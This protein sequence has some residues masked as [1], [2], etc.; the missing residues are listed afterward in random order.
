MTRKMI[1]RGAQEFFCIPCLADHF[2]LTEAVLRESTDVFVESPFMLVRT[3]NGNICINAGIDGSNVEG[4]YFITL[5]EAPDKAAEEIGRRIEEITGRRISVIV[6]DTNGRAFKIG[7]TN[8]AVG[9]YGIRAIRNWVGC[10]DLFDQV[11]EISEE[12]VVDEIAGAANLLMGEGNGGRPVVIVRG[13]SLRSDAPA[14]AGEMFR[15]ES[16]DAIVRGLLLMKEKGIHV[17]ASEKAG[18]RNQK[19]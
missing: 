2:E 6:T 10:R 13:L 9:L 18:L 12:A 14:A 8:V 11:L 7:Q 1:N 16:E 19:L 5:P 3:K 17:D 15:K 4:D